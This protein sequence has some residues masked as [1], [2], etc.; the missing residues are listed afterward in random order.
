M[1]AKPVALPP[2]IA[3][4]PSPTALLA[5]PS[6]VLLTP[7]A[8]MLAPMA[9]PES[10]GVVL[11][12]P[13]AVLKLPSAV[14]LVPIAVVRLLFAVAPFPQAVLNISPLSDPAGFEPAPPLLHSM[15]RTADGMS[16]GAANKA[17][18]TASNLARLRRSALPASFC[19]H[20]LPTAPATK[21]ITCPRV[22]QAQARQGPK[23]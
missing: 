13:I 19:R 1:L 6:A 7:L 15:A 14:A 10:P 12:A 2:A 23:V 5:V 4:L 16:G 22:A 20:D 11:P 9:V 8:R 18:A 3:A 21:L 17:H